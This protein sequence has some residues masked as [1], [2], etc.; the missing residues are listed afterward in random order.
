MSQKKTPGRPGARAGRSPANPNSTA[1]TAAVPADNPPT[2]R[3]G[4]SRATGA[5]PKGYPGKGSKERPWD[6]SCAQLESNSHSSPTD[7]GSKSNASQR[8]GSDRKIGTSRAAAGKRAST[9]RTAGDTSRNGTGTSRAAGDTSRNGTGT[10]RAAG[11]T[12]R[13]GTG[14]SRAAGDTSRNG[15]GTRRAAGDT[16][17]DTGDRR[18]ST[19]RAAGESSSAKDRNLNKML[20][21]VV[22]NLRIRS[23]EKS[24]AA[25]LVNDVVDYLLRY[26]KKD[27][28][29]CF[30]A[31]KKLPS[32]SYY[33]NVKISKPNE[34]DIM[35]TIPVKRIK[36]ME[37]DSEGAF[38]QVAF[39]RIPGANPLN[40]FVS[41]GMLSAEQMIC[42]LR[43]L[44]K[45]AAKTLPEYHIKVERKKPGSPAVTLQ[46]GEEEEHAPISLDI[47]LALEVHSQSWPSSTT[48]GLKIE[49][50]L[51]KKV[52]KDF[53]IKP[54]Y[55]VPKQP[56]DATQGTQS[57]SHK[58]G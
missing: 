22:E 25:R 3:P 4:S 45:A 5:L 54:F 43:K 47:V 17:R 51:G 38:Y 16:K 31:I 6:S 20:K 30:Q 24:R 41:D 33:E 27:S 50:W 1:P 9:S 35:I 55:L 2:K 11:G 14:T 13:N 34:F 46:I 37:V 58:G 39:K 42:H 7:T 12:S 18:T 36:I 15:T 57:Q 23:A 21:N 40:Q 19:S 10:S 26:I 48:D 56:L 49:E 53:R 32:G 29:R 8:G 28:G 52:R 44:I